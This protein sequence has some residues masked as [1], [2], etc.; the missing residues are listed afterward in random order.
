MLSRSRQYSLTVIIDR[1][2][3]TYTKYNNNYWKV[4]FTLRKTQTSTSISSLF[5]KLNY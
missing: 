5:I 3:V 2:A 4:Y 1:T